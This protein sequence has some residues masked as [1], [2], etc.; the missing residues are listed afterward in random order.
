[1][2]LPEP[3]LSARSLKKSFGSAEAQV[4]VFEG[5]SFDVSPTELVAIMGPSG[6]GKSTLLHLLAGLDEPDEGTVAVDGCQ[7]RE[8]SVEERARRRGEVIGFVF[9]FHHLL[10]ELTV[11]ENVALP[12]LL[13][14]APLRGA[15]RSARE[16][17]GRVDLMPRA[18]AYPRTL[19]GGE[20]QRAA[21][22]RAVVRRPKILLCDEPTGSLDAVHAAGVF[23]L[24]VDV[25]RERAGAAVVVTHDQDWAN[26]CA[27]IL[28]L[29]AE[30]LKPCA[31]DGRGVHLQSEEPSGSR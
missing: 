20:R 2:P 22:A 19:S 3:L 12:L 23:Q 28:N 15:L 14:G 16:C 26:R 10:P 29:T 4:V 8:M 7:W 6:C 11:E 30:G 1:M 13:S 31:Q 17:L 21:L 9:Q 27:R 5:C 24:L 18:S 25:A